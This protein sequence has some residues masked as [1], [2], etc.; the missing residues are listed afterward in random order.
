LNDRSDGSM[1]S[2][3]ASDRTCSI[4]SKANSV[5]PRNA[6]DRRLVTINFMVDAVMHHV[7]GRKLKPGNLSLQGLYTRCFR[8]RTELTYDFVNTPF[9]SLRI[10]L[11]Q[12]PLSGR[13]GSKGI[14]PCSVDRSDLFQM[15]RNRDAEG[16]SVM[17]RASQPESVSLGN[18]TVKISFRSASC[19]VILVSSN[20][21]RALAS[22]GNKLLHNQLG[23]YRLGS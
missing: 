3:S 2:M 20:C 18:R 11:S 15:F 12:V 16:A 17:S 4:S 7:R 22:S 8:K 9:W 5:S 14:E 1:E 19:P 23:T 13:T 10:R 6:S 21:F